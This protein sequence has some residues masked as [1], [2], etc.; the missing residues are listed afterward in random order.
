MPLKNRDDNT[1]KKNKSSSLVNKLTLLLG[2]NLTCIWFIA[3]AMNVFFSFENTTTRLTKELENKADLEVSLINQ[4]F[5]T[6]QRD[7]LLL[8]Q[9]VEIAP[10]NDKDFSGTFIQ[11]QTCNR[12]P[13]LSSA[14]NILQVSRMIDQKNYF[15][16]F[17]IQPE[18]GIALFT[19]KTLSHQE[20][21]KRQNELLDLLV[22][23][24]KRQYFLGKTEFM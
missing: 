2:I 1:M 18:K 4:R 17:I 5:Q 16:S 14:Q 6:A 15:F 13:L 19:P 12:V 22:W 7:A 23:F 24:S 9:I 20:L 10:Y 8:T 11:N 21:I 3:T